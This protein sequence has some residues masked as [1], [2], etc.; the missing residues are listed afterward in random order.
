MNMQ[1]VRGKGGKSVSRN[2]KFFS[3]MHNQR[4]KQECQPSVQIILKRKKNDRNLKRQKEK[5][6]RG[7]EFED[8]R[9]FLSVFFSTLFALASHLPLVQGQ[10]KDEK[11]SRVYFSM[12]CPCHGKLGK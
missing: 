7:T 1:G 3:V 10:A 2:F 11:F 12:N 8:K 9:A 5:L 4:H 6:P